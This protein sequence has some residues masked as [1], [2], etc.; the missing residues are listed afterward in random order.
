MTCWTGGYA[1]G[2]KIP[3]AATA[4]PNTRVSSYPPSRRS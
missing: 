4:P 3:V 2:T 1:S